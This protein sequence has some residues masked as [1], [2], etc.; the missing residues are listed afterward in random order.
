MQ[1]KIAM[2]SRLNNW[3]LPSFT[4]VFA[5]FPALQRYMNLHCKNRLLYTKEFVASCY[6]LMKRKEFEIVA[7]CYK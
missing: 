5:L 2:Q 7:S 1:C 4:V 3:A 6:K